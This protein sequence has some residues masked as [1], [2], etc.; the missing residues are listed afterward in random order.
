MPGAN[1]CMV[2]CS[3]SRISKGIGLFKLPKAWSKDH[4]KWRQD[5]INIITKTRKFP[6]TVRR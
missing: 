5:L 4:E 1:F 3:S 2:N 6:E